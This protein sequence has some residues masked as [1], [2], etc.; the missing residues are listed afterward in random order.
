MP[1]RGGG[2][3]PPPKQVELPLGMLKPR[4][5]EPAWFLFATLSETP[6]YFVSPPYNNPSVP[7]ARN[8]TMGRLHVPHNPEAQG[9]AIDLL[10]LPDLLP[11]P[12]VNLEEVEAR[13]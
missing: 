12:N 1:C 4:F 11:R 3:A 6:P 5:L 8:P 7:T 13:G 10:C 9:K 2:A